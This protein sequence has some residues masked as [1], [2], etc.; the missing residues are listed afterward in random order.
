LFSTPTKLF[1]RERR[2]YRNKEIGDLNF[3]ED[4][5]IFDVSCGLW[6]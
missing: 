6:S 4:I 5:V 1:S 3:R 2:G